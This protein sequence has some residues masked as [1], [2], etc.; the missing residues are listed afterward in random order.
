[1]KRRDFIKA[2]GVT[3]LMPGI[4]LSNQALIPASSF[5]NVIMQSSL[6]PASGPLDIVMGSLPAD[7]Y[8]HVFI[9]E[10]IPL[11]KNH[12]SPNGKGA[13]SRVDFTHGQAR[14]TRKMI[15]TPSAI[16][17]DKFSGLLDP[18]YLLGGTVYFS[19]NLG[20]M[21]YCNTAPNY[22]GN[23]RFALSY[24]GGIP[25][26]F[27]GTTLDLITPIGEVD[28]WKSSLPPIAEAFAPDKW[29]FPQ[30]RTTGHPYF[31]L[32]RN[33][34]F[35]INYGG[36]MGTSGL[37]NSFIRLIQWDLVGNFKTWNV[38]NR[39]G[40]N[41]F[42][43]ATS[44]SLGVTRHHILIFETAARVEN[45]RILGSK[46]VTPQNH[47]TP[48]WIIR[49]ADL[50]SNNSQV[51]ADYIELN[52]DT[53]DIVCNYDD[54]DNEITLYGQYLGAMDK[55]EPQFNHEKLLF[56]GY[57]SSDIA[58]YPVAPVD[59]G[60][61]VR[62]RLQVLS[63]SVREIVSDFQL[64]RD[65]AV[66]WDLNDPAYRGH[67]QFPEQ[68]DHIYW[69]AIGYR[70][71]HVVKRVAD[72]Y[73]NYPNRLFRNDQLPSYPVPSA[74]IHMDC[75]QMAISDSYQFPEDCVMRTPQFMAKNRSYTQDDG[76]IFT[77]VVRKYPSHANSNGKEFWIF[78][79]KQLAQGPIC[80]L[81]SPQLH[82]A[83]TNH[84]LWVP[85]INKRPVA[86]YQ[87]D[88]AGYFKEKL[89]FH[90]RQVQQAIKRH[91]LPRFS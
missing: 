31:D 34:C 9:A 6:K 73:K 7:L 32:E 67:F 46:K 71:E 41:A 13:L 23:N 3:G 16:L 81:A 47:H 64:I 29:L 55:S 5:P 60:G 78:D 56:G 28:E 83:T 15:E 90:S 52:F 85:T 54:Y 11:E 22:L 25:Y 26:E 8:G 65:Q 86:A 69:A 88:I 21:N 49:K 68:F 37:R 50:Q 59:V 19:P 10:G 61:L 14:F 39:Q 33:E 62:V 75:Q 57:V 84:A 72:A 12:L 53:S 66:C 89:S 48:V 27:D 42:I 18:F 63:D 43:T 82:F 4:T 36:N 30:V 20:F 44:H 2:A 80:I 17:Q 40:K 79:G 70:P 74:L 87:A 45:M 24:E 35:T 76:Y 58:G 38:V 51:V 1:M 91:I 77:A